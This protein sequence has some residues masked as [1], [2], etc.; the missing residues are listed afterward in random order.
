MENEYMYFNKKFAGVALIATLF[1][2]AGQMSALAQEFTE[3]HLAAAKRAISTSDST[4]RLDAILP[5][6]AQ[7][8]KA[9]L[10]RTRP[11]KEAEI[12]TIVDTAAIELAPRRGDL[13]NEI[14]LVFA[15]VFTEDEL[16]QIADFYATE[17]GKKFLNESP[18]VLREIDR[19]SQ[20]WANGLQRDMGASIREKLVAA[21]FN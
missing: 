20:V 5:Q 16:N 6:I 11:D 15:R 8:A 9:E 19:A 14:A 3:S 4:D 13:E 2:A 21:G 10:I 1:L 12:T 7:N 17:A 18:V